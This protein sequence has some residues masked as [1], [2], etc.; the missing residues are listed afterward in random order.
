MQTEGDTVL[1]VCLHALEDLASGLDGEHDGGKTRCKEDDVG[2][3]LGCFGRT[4]DGDTAVSLLKRWSVV[5]TLY[6][7]AHRQLERTR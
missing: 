1:D 5:D 7:L 6:R 2:G 3:G 4:L